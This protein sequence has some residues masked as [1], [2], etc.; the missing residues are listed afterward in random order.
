MLKKIND[1]LD[2]PI[3]WKASLKYTSVVMMIYGLTGLGYYAYCKLNARRF[4][5]EENFVSKF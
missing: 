4:E 2:K 5:N 3:T 1:A